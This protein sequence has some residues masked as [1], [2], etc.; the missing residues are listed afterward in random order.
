MPK[1]LVFP[2]VRVCVCHP[3]GTVLTIQEASKYCSVQSGSD[4]D[5][6]ITD[7]KVPV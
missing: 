1:L 6:T 7:R 3:H 2:C 5:S 4:C